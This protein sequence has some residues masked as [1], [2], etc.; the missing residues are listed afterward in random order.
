[1]IDFFLPPPRTHCACC[2]CAL[3]V[4]PCVPKINTKGAEA[5]YRVV[6]EVRGIFV[7]SWSLP[8]PSQRV[9][10]MLGVLLAL[11]SEKSRQSLSIIPKVVLEGG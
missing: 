6:I 8:K 1:M 3:V 2:R 7:V 4:R 9:S 11:I 5:L 10:G